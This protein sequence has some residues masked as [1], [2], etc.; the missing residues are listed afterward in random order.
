MVLNDKPVFQPSL[1][2]W[3][4]GF[5]GSV[6]GNIKLTSDNGYRGEASEMDYWLA[7]TLPGRA[8]GWTLT[9]YDYTF[10]HTSGVSTPGGVGHR[11]PESGAVQPV[12]DRDPRRERDQ[13]LVLPAHRLAEP[14]VAEATRVRRP[15]ADAQPGSRDE[16]VLPRVLS[17]DRARQRHRLRRPSRLAVQGRP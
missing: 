2:V 7:Y 10:P 14:G 3:G 6:W 12:L 8:V 17:G 11:K 15:G 9:Y 1:T 4:G 16:G 13:G 5:S